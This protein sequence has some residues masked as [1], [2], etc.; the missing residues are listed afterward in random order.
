MIKLHSSLVH[1]SVLHD[2]RLDHEALCRRVFTH[3]A[4]TYYRIVDCEDMIED[5]AIAASEKG[6]VVMSRIDEVAE[7]S[8]TRHRLH[9]EDEEFG[10]EACEGFGEIARCWCN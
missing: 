5:L 8:K 9:D 7:G 2:C 3:S 4:N 1:L 10:W 6:L